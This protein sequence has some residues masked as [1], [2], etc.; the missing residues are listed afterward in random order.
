MS[1]KFS[2]RWNFHHTLGALDGKHVA[3][4]CP[5]NSGSEYFNYK[6]FYSIVL[7]GLVDA[8]YKFVWVDIGAQGSASDAQVWNDSELKEAID[9]ETIG[10][11][12]AD[13]LPGDDDEHT[14]PYFIIGDDAFALR[15]WLMKPFSRRCMQHD[16]RIFNYRLSRARRIVENAFGILANRF[17]CLLTTLPQ[18]PETVKIIVM[19]CVCLHNIM[20]DRYPR[21]Q[22]DVVDREDVNHDLIPGAWRNDAQL[23]DMGEPVHGNVD[24]WRA[25][26]QRQELKAYYSSPVG[27][28]HWQ[29]NMI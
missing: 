24:A 26:R 20:R 13:P 14:M 22:N 12:A 7:M 18:E 16:E 21:G 29:D 28:V 23:V 6:K 8:D 15:T 2:A 1:D 9:A 25:K 3:I 19:S 5:K 11:P 4:R 10:F 27:A 17:R